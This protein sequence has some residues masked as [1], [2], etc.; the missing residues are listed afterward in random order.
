[1]SKE[2]TGITGSDFHL[3][4]KLTP[5]EEGKSELQG[6]PAK[7]FS[8]DFAVAA[9]G[10]LRVELAGQI[11]GTREG[12]VMAV[13]TRLAH[14]L[15]EDINFWLPDYLGG[16]ALN[17]GKAVQTLHEGALQSKANFMDE[18]T[19]FLFRRQP[20]GGKILVGLEMNGNGVRVAEVD[21]EELYQEIA[22]ALED[23][24]KQLLELNPKLAKEENIKAL[25]EY[26]KVLEHPVQKA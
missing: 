17:L 20:A 25:S 4:F 24:R 19:H 11:V 26:I 12:K 9:S 14:R 13:E 2:K 7:K 16:F 21:E 5:S 1:M 23:F 18:P 22:R 10:S 6:W 15:Q 8:P 3:E